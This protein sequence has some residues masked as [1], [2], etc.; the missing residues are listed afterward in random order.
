[1]VMKIQDVMSKDV[2]VVAPDMPVA[3]AALIMRNGDFGALPI[4]EN[5]RLKGMVTDRDIVLRVVAEGQ[6]PKQVSVGEIMSDGVF[7]VYEDEDIA[8]AVHNMQKQQVRR[9]PVVNREKRLTGIV[10]IGDLA[11][12]VPQTRPVA[13]ALKGVSKGTEKHH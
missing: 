1:M 4:G 5:D 10:S 6:D 2:Q 9:L 8:Q 13:T 11:V 12:E 7:W 3:E